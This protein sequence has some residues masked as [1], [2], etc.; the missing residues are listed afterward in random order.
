MNPESV[1]VPVGY[2]TGELDFDNPYNQWMNDY[3]IP[4]DNPI[5]KRSIRKGLPTDR[6]TGLPGDECDQS[7]SHC[8]IPSGPVSG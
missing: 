5:R 8:S 3:E 1:V 2:T 6:H 7:G 4:E